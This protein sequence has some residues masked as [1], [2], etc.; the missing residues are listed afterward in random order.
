MPFLIVTAAVYFPG[1]GNNRAPS[2]G[3]EFITRDRES[4]DSTSNHELVEFSPDSRSAETE[5]LPDPSTSPLD[6]RPTGLPTPSPD[7]ESRLTSPLGSWEVLGIGSP[8]GSSTATVPANGK[9]GR[10]RGERNLRAGGGGG[11]RTE[12]SVLLALRW[13]ARHQESDGKWGAASFSTQCTG[14]PCGGPGRPGFEPAVTGLCV[15]TF[16]GAGYTQRSKECYTDPVTQRVMNFGAC[17]RSALEW[18]TR[19]QGRDGGFGPRGV[20]RALYN[21]AIAALALSEAYGLSG[22]PALRAPAQR[23]L[24]YLVSARNPRGAWRYTPLADPPAWDERRGAIDSYW[25]FGSLALS[26][27]DPARPARWRPGNRALVR[28]LVDHQVKKHN[29]CASGS[30]DAEEA[31]T[32]EGGRVAMTALKVLALQL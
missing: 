16:L 6:L 29:A 11:D 20:Q 7:S 8:G 31:W 12:G 10:L 4:L 19:N 21:E 28:A 2:V 17:V 32:S 18:L 13:L 24:D 25:Y 3:F 23:A 14:V 22:A 15:L 30:W 5:V 27:I 9:F 26:P 1:F